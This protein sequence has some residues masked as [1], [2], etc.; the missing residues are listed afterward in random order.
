MLASW[1]KLVEVGAQVA[2]ALDSADETPS[3]L[4]WVPYAMGAALMEELEMMP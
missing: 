4:Q 2:F 3:I 1:V